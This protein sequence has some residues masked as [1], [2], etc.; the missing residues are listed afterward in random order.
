LKAAINDLPPEKLSEPLLFPWGRTGSVRQ[1]V[2]V[3]AH[4]EGEEHLGELRQMKSTA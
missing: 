1:L 2:R 3:I 4:H